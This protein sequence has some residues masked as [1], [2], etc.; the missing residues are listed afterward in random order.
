MDV[1]STQ[2]QSLIASLSV[3]ATRSVSIVQEATSGSESVLI[4]LG[5]QIDLSYSQRVLQDSLTSSFDTAL[6]DAGLE[7]DVQT[8]LS[9]G[10]DLSPQATAQRIVDFAVSFFDAFQANHLDDDGKESQVDS[11]SALIRGAVEEGFAD[12]RSIIEGIGPIREGVAADIDETFE[13]TMRGIDEFAEQ[14]REALLQQIEQIV[15]PVQENSAMA[16]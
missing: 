5:Q 12:A 3:T 10:L 6:S 16:V 14:Q 7:L 11:F 8:L 9:S 15:P 13:L 4:S 2:S 1:G